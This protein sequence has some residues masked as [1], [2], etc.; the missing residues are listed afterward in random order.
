MSAAVE[1]C[2]VR[3]LEM[4]EIDI[5]A[6]YV[7]RIAAWLPYFDDGEHQTRFL[8]GRL[9]NSIV[10]PFFHGTVNV[11]LFIAPV[12]AFNQTLTEDRTVN[13]LVR[14]FVSSSEHR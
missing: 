6:H 11:L 7:I 8:L 9:I 4:H 5:L 14:L 13:R 12:S 2:V 10:A 1:P 3:D